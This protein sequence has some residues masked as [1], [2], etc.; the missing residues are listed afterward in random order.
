MINFFAN[1]DG[2]NKTQE[3]EAAHYLTQLDC[4]KLAKA[5]D[6]SSK[7]TQKMCQNQLNLAN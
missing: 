5:G 7:K 2:T 6:L 4:M 3:E 1:F